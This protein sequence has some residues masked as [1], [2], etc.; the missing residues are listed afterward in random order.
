MNELKGPEGRTRQWESRWRFTPYIAVII[1]FSFVSSSGEAKRSESKTAVMAEKL[2]ALRTEINELDAGLRTRRTLAAT[3]LRSL[4]TRASELKLTE[5]A[6]RIH[7]QALEVEVRELEASISSGDERSASLEKAVFQAT[8]R[9]QKVTL[10]SLPFKLEQRLDALAQIDRGLKD[11]TI[12]AASAAAQM[13]RFVEDER[14][15]ATTVALDDE[16]IVL[17]GDTRPSLVRV[18]R[19]GTVAMFVYAGENRWGRVVREPKGDFEYTDI[20]DRA[21]RDEIKRLFDS[22][23]KQIREGRYRLPLFLTGKDQ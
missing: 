11:G 3:E 1:F 2:A 17:T 13:W 8:S 20:K 10:T 12:D 14:R 9:L 6:E 16:R 5:D 22:V 4:Q 18:V 23:E 7:V 19:V 21:Q 15:L